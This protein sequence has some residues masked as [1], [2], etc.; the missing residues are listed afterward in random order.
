[1]P[2]DAG[3]NGWIRL[4]G[5]TYWFLFD[6]GFNPRAVPLVFTLAEGTAPDKNPVR[7]P[8]NWTKENARREAL[9]RALKAK[10]LAEEV[11]SAPAEA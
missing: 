2:S 4:D 5:K 6:A 9:S 7:E 8:K 3:N 1:V 10:S 11:A